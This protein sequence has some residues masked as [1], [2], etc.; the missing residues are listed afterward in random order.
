MQQSLDREVQKRAFDLEANAAYDSNFLTA[1][2]IIDRTNDAESENAIFPEFEMHCGPS[3]QRDTEC[4]E[5]GPL[6]LLMVVHQL[7]PCSG[8]FGRGLQSLRS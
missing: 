6:R 1:T 8:H 3:R 5:R 2:A 4:V 7:F